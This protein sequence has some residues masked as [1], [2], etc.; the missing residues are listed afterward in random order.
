[1][2]AP[3]S[4]PPRKFLL[5]EKFLLTGSVGQQRTTKRNRN[6]YSLPTTDVNLGSP[7]VAPIT[8]ATGFSSLHPTW[9]HPKQDV[10]TTSSNSPEMSLARR[11]C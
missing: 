7:K 3:F 5:T 4:Q 6:N 1:M 9:S 8:I 10:N 2:A 11:S